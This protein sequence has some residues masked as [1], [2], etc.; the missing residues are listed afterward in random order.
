MS[1]KK[2]VLVFLVMLLSC[3]LLLGCGSDAEQQSQ[4]EDIP[5]ELVIGIGRDFYDGPESGNF[6][7]PSTGVWESLT[8]PGIDLEPMMQLA[9]KIDSADNNQVWTVF[10]R[11]QVKFHDGSPLNAEAVVKS[12][13]RLKDNPE[14]DEYS[15]FLTLDK[16]EATDDNTVKFTFNRSQPG[17]AAMVA[18]KGC[19]I[20]SIKSFDEEG[21]VTHP[22][23]TGPFKFEDYKKDEQLVITRNDNYWGGE[24]KLEK[25]TFK[26]VPDP[27]TR[28]AALTAGEIDAIVDVGGILPEQ[29][30]SIKKDENL[31]LLTQPV[32]TSHYVVFNNK[33]E[34]FND[35]DL[36]QAVSLSLDRKELVDKVMSGY[37]QPA[38]TLYTPL[39]EKW[40]TKGLW[41]T[42]K[43]KAKELATKAEES[44]KVD[45]IVNAALANRWPY[46]S[47]AEI[48]QSELKELNLDVEIKTVEGAAWGDTLK[49]GE[50][51]MTLSPYTLMTGDPDFYFGQWIDS[52]GQMNIARGLGYNNPEADRLVAE[53]ATGKDAAARQ[54]VYGELDK[55]VAEDVPVAP[56]YNDVCIY[57][58]KKTV[59]DLTIDPF[60]KPSLEKAWISK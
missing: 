15:T 34:P 12:V 19:P 18:G 3:G 38:E 59:N 52:Q 37:G 1:F 42:D 31:V 4:D 54:K 5:Q 43:A 60:F 48:L 13:M 45:L 25:V 49:N 41:K 30:S 16:V 26:T 29:S 40:V 55:L 11:Q 22:Y 21:K 7:H 57:A 46:K 44:Q 6:L 53:A 32:T 17:F 2:V 36:R 27:S 28:L 47:I 8:Y 51:D 9:T 10:L 23:G 58:T 56:I 24:A 50:Y 14:L 35:K 20:F 39:A 33:K